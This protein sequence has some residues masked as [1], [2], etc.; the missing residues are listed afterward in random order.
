MKTSVLA[1][2]RLKI[3]LW[4]EAG[5]IETS[6]QLLLPVTPILDAIVAVYQFNLTLM[7]YVTLPRDFNPSNTGQNRFAFYQGNYQY[8]VRDN[9]YED[10]Y[11]A[12]A[13]FVG[14]NPSHRTPSYYQSSLH[15]TTQ[16]LEYIQQNSSR[17]NN[18]S[19]FSSDGNRGSSNPRFPRNANNRPFCAHCNIYGHAPQF[20]FA[21]QNRTQ[22]K[23]QLKQRNLVHPVTSHRPA[24]VLT[25]EC[26]T[27]MRQTLLVEIKID[28]KGFA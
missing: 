22:N 4:F 26:M 17:T 20:S 9:S 23:Q 5:V 6:H 12:S 3:L 16:Q 24:N 27:E 8:F 21:W 19:S 1:L 2:L 25:A 15:L 11:R 10:D 7:V 28:N 13:S 18:T 14:N